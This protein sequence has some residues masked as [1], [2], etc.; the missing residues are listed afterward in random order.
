MEVKHSA[1]II[2]LPLKNGGSRAAILEIV[3]L[4]VEDKTG[5]LMS[6][7]KENIADALFE[8]MSDIG[9]KSALEH[10]FNVMRA[11]KVEEQRYRSKFDSLLNE[12]WSNFNLG[13]SYTHITDPSGSI[14]EE[15]QMLSFK[16]SNHY[17]VLIQET[18][19]RF[20][21]LLKRNIIDHPLHPDLFYYSFW[22]ALAELDITYEERSFVLPL[23]HRF[24]MDRYGQ[25]L[26]V[27]NRALIELKVDRTIQFPTSSQ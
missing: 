15:I 8:E 14:A 4:Q 12:T 16:V 11:M 1:E 24:V 22:Q 20:Q 21:T 25:I 19:F 5:F 23:F 18:R 2:P 13:T 10:H 3:K 26:A 17:K 6:G 7:L 9:E 27:A